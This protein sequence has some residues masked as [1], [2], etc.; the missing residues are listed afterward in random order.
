VPLAGSVGLRV[1]G[2]AGPGVGWLRRLPL[3]IGILPLSGGML[4]FG[5]G[6][7]P[8]RLAV[9]KLVSD[10]RVCLEWC[11]PHRVSAGAVFRH[12][13]RGHAAGGAANEL[14]LL[15]FTAAQP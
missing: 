12:P 8:F 3:W 1:R 14:I 11:S 7:R 5:E 9:L 4:L 6:W 10:C 2:G 15:R 13:V